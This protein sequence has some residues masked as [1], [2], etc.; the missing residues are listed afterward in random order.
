MLNTLS[1]NQTTLT[2]VKHILTQQNHVKHILKTT[3]SDN[4]LC[5][6]KTMKINVGH[7]YYNNFVIKSMKIHSCWFLENHETFSQINIQEYLRTVYNIHT[8]P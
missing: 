8:I 3:Y 2:H 4:E 7:I 5:N 6:N 1:H